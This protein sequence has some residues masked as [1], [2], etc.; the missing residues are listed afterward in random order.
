MSK[1]LNLTL[2]TATF[3][4]ITAGVIE[5]P[6]KKQVRELLTFGTIPTANEIGLRA[7]KLATIA[8]TSGCQSAMIDGPPYLMRPLE[9]ALEDI[10]ING[11]F[12]FLGR[13]WIET[14]VGGK[15]V[16]TPVLIHKGWL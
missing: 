4:Q 10:G 1:I 9:E 16:R 7:V 3:E 11:L 2:H 8:G 6:S 5:P 14:K 15:T 13:D 12:S